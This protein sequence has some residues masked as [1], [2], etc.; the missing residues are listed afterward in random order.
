MLRELIIALLIVFGAAVWRA[1]KVKRDARHE[2]HSFTEY[3]DAFLFGG[4]DDRGAS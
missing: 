3:V 2:K 4:E 1:V